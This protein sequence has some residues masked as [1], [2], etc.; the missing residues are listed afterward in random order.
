MENL[1]DVI[2]AKK[3]LMWQMFKSKTKEK[4]KLEGVYNYHL[5]NI[6]VPVL[7]RKFLNK[8]NPKKTCI[9]VQANEKVIVSED[10]LIK[11]AIESVQANKEYCINHNTEHFGEYSFFQQI[12]VKGYFLEEYSFEIDTEGEYYLILWFTPEYLTNRFH[13]HIFWYGKKNNIDWY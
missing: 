3:S 7:D 12:E 2:F 5:T 1:K 11:E 13:K 8:F 10:K 4:T 9:S 6:E